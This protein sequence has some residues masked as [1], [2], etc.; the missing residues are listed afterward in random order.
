MQKNC[1]ENKEQIINI[2]ESYRLINQENLNNNNKLK[3]V[4]TSNI[5]MNSLN[6]KCSKK[7]SITTRPN[8]I[9]TSKLRR[10]TMDY[11]SILSDFKYFN[12]F[13]KSLCNYR[14]L[15]SE[16]K[17]NYMA[18]YYEKK[19]KLAKNFLFNEA[20]GNNQISKIFSKDKNNLNINISQ[21]FKNIEKSNSSQKLTFKDL[22]IK[23]NN[24]K[25]SNFKK[26]KTVK[27]KEEPIKLS[28]VEQDMKKR[29]KVNET[30]SPQQEKFIR[31][32]LKDNNLIDFDEDTI[33]EFIIGF[34]SFEVESN[35]ALYNEDDEARVF[36]IIEEGNIKIIMKNGNNNNEGNKNSYILSKGDYFGLECFQE[37]TFRNQTAISEGKAKL[38]GVSGEFY[39]SALIYMD[40]KFTNERIE[41]IQNLFFFKFIEKGKQIDLCKALI[42]NV[43]EPNSIIINEGEFSNRIF[44][45]ENGIVRKTR[46]FKKIDILKNN[47]IFFDINFF[48]NIPSFFTYSAAN[49]EVFIYELCYSNIKE[50]LGENCL[51]VILYNIFSNSIQSSNLKEIIFSAQEE[52][53]DIFK[54]SYT[55]IVFSFCLK[56]IFILLE[57]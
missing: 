37:N 41:I 51:K 52:L 39:R 14:R 31:M 27:E 44:I 47:N 33:N 10:N 6:Y 3:A 24:K 15:A 22:T 4:K 42:L 55:N 20:M 8:S 32:T 17:E 35:Y 21:S 5:S 26:V 46:K 29:Y 34:F 18:I 38:L 57:K 30:L 19:R 23:E 53:F 50:I 43:Y 25:K 36:Y 40:L 7:Q 11:Q 45:I 28:I 49:N 1:C 9:I 56:K 12:Q 13:N 54:L 48:M 16:K 2:Q